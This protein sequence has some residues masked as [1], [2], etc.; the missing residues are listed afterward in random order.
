MPKFLL[1]FFFFS[2]STKAMDYFQHKSEAKKNYK[3]QKRIFKA[4][5]NNDP[6]EAEAILA[7]SYPHWNI[8]DH[9]YSSP[10]H[11][12]ILY[13][14]LNIIKLLVL[15]VD[16]NEKALIQL[17]EDVLGGGKPEY[18]T[19][20]EYAQILKRREI[21]KFLKDLNLSI[22]NFPATS[23]FKKLTRED[24]TIDDAKNKKFM[25]KNYLIL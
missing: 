2:L 6:A 12:A 3:C 11:T 22:Q 17:A 14:N 20:L 9:G 10:L 24:V 16:I 19:P 13:N 5:R 4:I 1:A 21:V 25:N 15:H 18:Y 23:N 7:I 8:T